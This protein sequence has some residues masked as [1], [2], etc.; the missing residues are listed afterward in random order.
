M[1]RKRIASRHGERT[2]KLPLTVRVSAEAHLFTQLVPP[3]LCSTITLLPLSVASTTPFSISCT[4]GGGEKTRGEENT[5]LWID[6]DF[7]S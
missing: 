6:C 7:F 5:F 2:F 4:E 3:P 1:A